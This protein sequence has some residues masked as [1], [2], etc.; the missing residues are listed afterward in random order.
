[1]AQKVN[2]SQQLAIQSS[3]WVTPSLGTGWT[4]FDT[5]SIPTTSTG[6][7]R[8]P[9]YVIDG[10][11]CVHME[12]LVKANGSTNTPSTNA[13]V[14]T[15]PAGLRPGHTLRF[16]TIGFNGTSDIAMA[17]TIETNGQVLLANPSSVPN[18]QWISLSGISFIAEQ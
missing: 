13:L 12:G 8:F 9:R 16:V 6:Q 15:L 1:M 5:G 3:D 14:F 7:Y 11:G 2:K 18:G 17:F 10:A 4:Q